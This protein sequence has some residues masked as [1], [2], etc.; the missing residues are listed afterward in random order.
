[1]G[2]LSVDCGIIHIARSQAIP[3]TQ[4]SRPQ[5]LLFLLWLLY[6]EKEYGRQDLETFIDITY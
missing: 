6:T 4:G 1:M 5:G 2:L 3:V